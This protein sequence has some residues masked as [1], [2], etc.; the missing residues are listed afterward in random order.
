MF[1]LKRG[2]S[3]EGQRVHECKIIG[4]ACFPLAPSLASSGVHKLMDP[5]GECATAKACKE[6]GESSCL[7][8]ALV[9]LHHITSRVL[10]S[11][12]MKSR[13]CQMSVLVEVCISSQD[14]CDKVLL[15]FLPLEHYY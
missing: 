7:F 4:C 9:S 12:V 13:I 8:S 11:F 15:I 5:E 6:A 3:K 1:T 10:F 2:M 14:D